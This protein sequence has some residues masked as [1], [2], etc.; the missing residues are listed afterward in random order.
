MESSKDKRT[1]ALLQSQV[2]LK[3]YVAYMKDVNCPTYVC[4]AGEKKLKQNKRIKT[5]KQ[6]KNPTRSK[7]QYTPLPP[8]LQ[9]QPYLKICMSQQIFRNTSQENEAIHLFHACHT[10]H[11]CSEGI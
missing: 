4:S 9:L 8:K 5:N 3:Q 7:Q 10:W 1:K 2:S 11:L 6:K